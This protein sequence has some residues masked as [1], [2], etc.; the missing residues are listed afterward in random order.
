MINKKVF[1]KEELENLIKQGL[2]RKDIADMFN[3]S[4]STVIYYSHKHK[5]TFVKEHVKLTNKPTND[6]LYQLY[7]VQNLTSSEIA[8]MYGAKIK[9]VQGW[10]ERAGFR[11]DRKTIGENK[12]KGLLKAHGGKHPMDIAYY[13]SLTNTTESLAKAKQT[14]RKKYGV[15][16]YVALPEINKLS[17]SENAINKAINTCQ[18]KFGVDYPCQL[19]GVS[20]KG[21]SQEGRLKAH[22]TKKENGSYKNSKEEDKAYELLI[23]IYPEV[24]RQ[25]TDDRYPFPCDFYI[26]SE[27]L[28]I[29]Y[30][31]YFTHG[32]EPY[33]PK[34]PEHTKFVNYWTQ[35][36]KENPHG[37]GSHILRTFVKNDPLKR[38]LAKENNL[39][40]LEFFSLKAMEEYYGS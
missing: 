16:A 26:P 11:K 21:N 5:V 2:S 34:N 27:D 12:Y 24:L 6:E 31:G 33:N 15:D 35:K 38:Q 4:E 19:E 10:C 30:N 23:S 8:S 40:W 39:N 13:K 25:Y 7:I 32:T 3:V 28:F 36:M 18:T 20:A 37:H 22:Q 14:C 17:H 9:T 1:S 29:E